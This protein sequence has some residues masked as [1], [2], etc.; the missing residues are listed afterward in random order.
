MAIQYKEMFFHCSSS[1]L[2]PF[3]NGS[4]IAGYTKILHFQI[5]LKGGIHDFK[6]PDAHAENAG[7]LGTDH[8]IVHFFGVVL[9]QLQY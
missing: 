1:I 5:Q 7:W 2:R 3:I 9:P 8:E 4:S 6:T